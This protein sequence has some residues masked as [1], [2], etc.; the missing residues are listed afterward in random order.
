MRQQV[1]ACLPNS[2]IFLNGSSQFGQQNDRPDCRAIFWVI[3]GA[4]RHPVTGGV[5]LFQNSCDGAVAM[6]GAPR[7]AEFGISSGAA[8]QVAQGK[9]A[10]TRN[11]RLQ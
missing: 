11:V 5:H 7:G 10:H 3:A 6:G 4:G 8:Q 9:V 1:V 2:R